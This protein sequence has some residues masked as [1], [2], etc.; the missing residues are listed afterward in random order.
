MAGR[1]SGRAGAEPVW[2]FRPR[3]LPVI[4]TMMALSLIAVFTVVWVRLATRS[5][6]TAFQI[7]TLLAFGGAMLWILYRMATL[8]I[9]AYEDRVE[10]R[11]VFRSYRLDWNRVRALR[12]SPGDPW[13]QLFDADGNRIGV[14]AI[15]SADGSRAGVAARELAEVGRRHGAGD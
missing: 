15:Q 12:F 8:R 11:N 3:V 1:T 13:L 5:E 14:L 9:A 4:A 6:F 10:V 2:R 7:V